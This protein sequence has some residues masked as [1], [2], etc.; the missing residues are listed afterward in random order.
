MRKKPIFFISSPYSKVLTQE[1][2]GYA[3]YSHKI[4]AEKIVNFLKES[5]KVHYVVD[6]KDLEYYL[7]SNSKS[8]KYFLYIGPPDFSWT[9]PSC[10]N[11]LLFTWEFPD[12]P[13]EPINDFYVDW[14]S[15]LKKFE[16]VI[17]N[18]IK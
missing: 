13:L 15:K 11:Y 7:S 9:S 1:V 3:A 10:T 4:L 8:Q 14:I 18:S 12:I 2:L 5:F 6:Q 16:M 17:N